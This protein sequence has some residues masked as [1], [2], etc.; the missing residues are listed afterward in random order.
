M[1]RSRGQKSR[2]KNKASLPQVPKN[3]KEEF[4]AEFAE[5]THLKK[6]K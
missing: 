3:L 2:D 1:G 4:S 6:Q 5:Q